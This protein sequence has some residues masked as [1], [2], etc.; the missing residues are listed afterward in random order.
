MESLKIKETD[1][2]AALRKELV[3]IGCLLEEKGKGVWKLTPGDKP[4]AEEK[5]RINTYRDHRMAMGFAP[6]AMLAD[7]EI[8]N[9]DVVQK[10]YPRFWEDVKGLGIVVKLRVS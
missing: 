9:P 1:R 4:S 10:S 6:W 7:I 5:L 8:E 2:I 3:K